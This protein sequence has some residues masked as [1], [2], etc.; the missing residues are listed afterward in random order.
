MATAPIEYA[1]ADAVAACLSSEG[2]SQ[3]LPLDMDWFFLTRN[4]VPRPRP[5]TP[6]P[7]STISAQVRVI[8]AFDASSGVEP[9]GS[10]VASVGAGSAG[11]TAGVATATAAAAPAASASSRLTIAA[12]VE[13]SRWA[14]SVR[15]G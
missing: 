4:A 13:A 5:T 10:D 14:F 7:P 3:A 6:T 9:E 12:R 1:T 11:T 15:C 2:A 8:L